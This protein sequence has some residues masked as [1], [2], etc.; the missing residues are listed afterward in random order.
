MG[1]IC[2][3]P[4]YLALVV[5]TITEI[6]NLKRKHIYKDEIMILHFLTYLFLDVSFYYMIIIFVFDIAYTHSRRMDPIFIFL[7]LL[8]YFIYNW[9]FYYILDSNDKHVD[10]LVDNSY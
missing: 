1:L 10:G 9:G 3:G 7:C 4:H 5:F 8:I 6:N 2:L